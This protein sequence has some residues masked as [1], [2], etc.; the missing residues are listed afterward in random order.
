MAVLEPVL[1]GMNRDG[2]VTVFC[3][4]MKEQVK[5]CPEEIRRGVTRECHRVDCFDVGMEK[6]QAARDLREFGQLP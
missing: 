6:M 1:S 2:T 5:A 4:C 3:W